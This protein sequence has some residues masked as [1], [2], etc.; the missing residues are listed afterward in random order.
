MSISTSIRERVKEVLATGLKKTTEEIGDDK[1]I[2][3]DSG[4]D[5]LDRTELVMS[6]EEAF[7]I[8]IPDDAAFQL[9]TVGDV[10]N[11]VE[12]KLNTAETKR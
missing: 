1:R 3:E 7:E 4:A 12:Q 9:L 2:A 10:I 8:E 6:L 5:S 11:F